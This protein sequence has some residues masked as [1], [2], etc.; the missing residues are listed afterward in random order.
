M[1]YGDEIM[2]T[3]FARLVKLKNK[4]LLSS[5][6]CDIYVIAKLQQWGVKLH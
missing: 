6:F 3:G 2:S 4:D 5:K 1:G